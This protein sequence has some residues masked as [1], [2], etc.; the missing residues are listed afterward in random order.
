LL[1]FLGVSLLGSGDGLWVK[2]LELLSRDNRA[3][4][5]GDAISGRD[6]LPLDDLGVLPFG[7]PTSDRHQSHQRKRE[8]HRNDYATLHREPSL[9]PIMAVS[10]V[11]AAASFSAS[12]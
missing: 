10:W 12:G 4:A 9:E 8:E 11:S 5:P 6:G 2:E 1:A 7:A 3:D